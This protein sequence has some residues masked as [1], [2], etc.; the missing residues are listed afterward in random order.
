MLYSLGAFGRD[1]GRGY[2][3]NTVFD[4]HHTVALVLNG[5]EHVQCGGILYCEFV[6]MKVVLTF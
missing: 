1:V 6:E 3:K 2:V 5:F 4:V